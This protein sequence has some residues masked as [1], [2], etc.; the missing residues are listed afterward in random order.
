MYPFIHLAH[1]LEIPTF[2]LVISIV[3]SVSL[4]WVSKRAA[5][6]DLP[7]H[8]VLDLSLVLMIAALV[9]S[10]LFHVFYE[11]PEYY[12][13]D[14]KKIFFLWDGGFVFFGGAFLAFFSA[15]VYFKV[16]RTENRGE[17]FDTFAPVLAFAYG[18][19]RIGCFLAGCCYGGVCALPWAVNGRH[20]TQLYALLWESAALMILLGVEKVPRTERP[21]FLRRSG[22]LFVLWV[23]LHTSGRLLMES[24]RDDFRGQTFAGLSISTLFCLL[25]LVAVILLFFRKRKT[26]P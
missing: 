2:F 1:G 18:F 23:A 11:N 22:D 19:G 4:I 10:R 24:Y 13:N 25:L 5:R 8:K 14:P 9:G 7:I 6:A 16:T 3:V 21:I 17:Y 26:T 15:W 12:Q 20:P